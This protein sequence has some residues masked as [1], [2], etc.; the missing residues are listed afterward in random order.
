MMRWRILGVVA[1]MVS[2]AVLAALTAAGGGSAALQPKLGKPMPVQGSTLFIDLGLKDT[3]AKDWG[4]SIRTSA[5]QVIA[6]ATIG[7]GMETVDGESWK[8]KSVAA[9]KKKQGVTPVAVQATL[10][11]PPDAA[12]RV[13]TA[14]GEFEFKISGIDAKKGSLFLDGQARVRR[15]PLTLR[16][17]DGPTE[18]DFPAAATAPDGTVWVA[19]V[20][21]K[22]GSPIEL[23]KDGSIPDDWSS[24][25]TKGHGDQIKLVRFDGKTWSA[26]VDVTAPGR[27]VWRPAVGVQ[28]GRVYVAWSEVVSGEWDLHVQE[29]DAATSGRLGS[30]SLGLK[31]ADINPTLAASP[32]GK[33]WLAWMHWEKDNFDIYA[34]DVVPTPDS[35]FEKPTAITATAANEWHPAAAVDSDGTLHVAYDTYDKG[36]YDVRVT[37]V[38][39]TG[40]KT[41]AVAESARFEARPAIA[42]DRQDRVWVAYE[43]AGEEWGKD[44]GSRWTGPS[45]VAFYIERTIEV[46]CLVGGQVMQVVRPESEKVD[47]DMLVGTGANG[48]NLRLSFPRLAADAAGRIWLAFRRHPLVNGNGERWASF[49][50]CCDGDRWSDETQ[51]PSSDNLMDNRPA[52]APLKDRGLLVVYS[53]DHRTGG[54]N[55]AGQ[56]DLHAAVIAA[57]GEPKQ[58]KFEVATSGPERPAVIV[59]PYET[60]DVKRMRE[61]RVSV[62][63]KS[64]Q[65]LRGEFHR[66]TEIS[67]HRDQDGPFEEIWRYGL[68]VAR[69]DWIGPGDHDNGVGPAGIT[70]EYTWWL[71]QKQ[72]DMYFHAPT[73]MP[74]FTYERSV[75]YPSGHRNVIFAKR[76]IRPLPRL[77]GDER[78]FGTPEGGAPDVKRFYA[79]LKHFGGICSSHTSATNMGTDWRDNDP[80]VEPVVEI[81][82]GHRQNYEHK[83]APQSAKDAADSIGGYQE[84]GYVWNAW[85]KGYRLGTQVSSDHVSTHLSYGVVL[86]EKPTREGIVDAFKR[87]HSYGAQDNIVLVVQCGEHLMGDEFGTREP[88]TLRISAIGTAPIARVSIVRG[89][90]R[91]LPTYVYNAEPHEVNVSLRWTDTMA[92]AGETSYYYVRIEQTDKK[93]AWASPMWIKY[94]K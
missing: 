62:G 35:I 33:L 57:H 27:D 80:A 83:D 52:L 39:R 24:L 86:A 37:S 55:T 49:V 20:A 87:R 43:Q 15:G 9:K 7:G 34:L 41:T 2:V 61:H 64:Y 19:Y 50:T 70:H 17:T 77:Q 60:A 21:Y 92:V 25:V 13:T 18:D 16:L 5:G 54:T 30:R 26:P 58:P 23:P 3:E 29:F 72:I 10:D 71:S 85:Q 12:V 94:E 59:H 22:H 76:G 11:S 1:G 47:T 73:F 90:G 79:Y 28:G 32:D 53:S 74:M 45:G 56:N 82:Q 6:L 75:V 89:V 8:A 65:L 42:V 91:E 38:S 46:R 63:G 68:D 88:P 14:H 36:N 31:G 93:L 84:A 81:F 66:H 4:G 40:A 69:M 44:Y 48:R 78:L 51:L 67:A